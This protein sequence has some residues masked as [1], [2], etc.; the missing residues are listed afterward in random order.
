MPA[1][2][3]VAVVG[4][5]GAGKSTISRILYRFYDI[6]SGSVTIDGQDIRDVTQSSLRAAIGIVPQ[7]TVLFNDTIRYNIGYGRIGASEERDS[8]S[9]APGADRSLHPPTAGRLQ[10][11]GRRA[12]AET[13]RRREA[14]RRDR[15]HA[16]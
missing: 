15:A 6:Q 11:H 9:R 12:R 14:A 16:C 3:T 13:L 4:P 7:D 8:R 1:G 5:S 2:K 10:E